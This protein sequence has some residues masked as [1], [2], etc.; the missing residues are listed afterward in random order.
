MSMDTALTAPS[1][2]PRAA[3]INGP[4]WDIGW[5]IG[6]CAIVPVVLFFVWMGTSSDVI[7]IGVTAL[8][9]G[10]HL[11]ATYLVTYMDPAFR[12][13]HRWVLL[14]AAILV[15]AFVIYWTLV[16]FQILLSVFIFAASVHVLHQN[17]YLT[18]IYRK[19]VG[20]AEPAWSRLVD[21]GLLMICIYPIASY[22]LVNSNF[23][24]GEIQILIPPFL[25]MPAT[26]WLVWITFAFFLAAF[27]G[28]TLAEWKRGVLNAPK[29]LLIAV[30]TSI[31][32]VVP[33]AASGERLEL[34][35][36]S[37]NAWHSI[38]YLGMV[39]LIQK[40]RKDRGLIGSGFVRA[41]SGSGRSTW[42]FYGFVVFVTMGLF[43]VLVSFATLDPFGLNAG[44]HAFQKYYY[45][46]VLSCLLIHYVLDGY[47]FTV[48][49][50]ASAKVESMPYAA[51]GVIAIEQ[52][53]A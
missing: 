2:G 10:P 41:L 44:Q 25:M 22:K 7:N 27:I 16:D 19:R 6:S 43:G 42:R 26:Y 11:F 23:M 29:T 35:F 4:R 33:M 13:K 9:G 36:Q 47:M 30:T 8:I 34:A 31:A 51:P 14:A 28:K 12:K 1:G 3:W 37:V 49:N 24:L 48:S 40:Y 17:A 46:G 45:M 50:T 20:H 18:D 52:R 15:P 53:A 5:L 32:F 21:Y 38:Q 39:W